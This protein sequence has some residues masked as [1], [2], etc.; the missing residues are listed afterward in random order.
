MDTLS[1]DPGKHCGW[2][3]YEGS[4]LVATGLHKDP[5]RLLS[6]DPA[7]IASDIAAGVL[8]QLKVHQGVPLSLAREIEI[9]YERPQVYV[10]GVSVARPADL[11]FVAIVGAT[12]A[13]ACASYY[14]ARG[15]TVIGIRSYLPV[16]WV[17]GRSKNVKKGPW[18]NARA[19]HVAGRLTPEE[20][21]CVLADHN[22]IDAV[23][24][25]L[26]RIGRSEPKRVSPRR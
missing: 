5:K 22:V 20:L 15:N 10:P 19:K 25:G 13:Q 24:I 1:I 9:V 4:K 26:Y 8:A 18:E 11:I 12:V 6:D 23:G 14:R 16:Q 21:D 7:P 17:G 2:A 3:Y